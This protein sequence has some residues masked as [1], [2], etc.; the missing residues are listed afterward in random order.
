MNN[1]V[2]CRLVWI[3][4]HHFVCVSFWERTFHCYW[5]V[6]GII[7]WLDFLFWFFIRVWRLSTLLVFAIRHVLDELNFF[8]LEYVAEN[9]S[10][11]MGIISSFVVVWKKPRTFVICET[12]FDVKTSFDVLLKFTIVCDLFVTLSKTCFKE[13]FWIRGKHFR[14]EMNREIGMPGILELFIGIW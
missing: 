3:H 6:F 9:N 11:H 7:W 14:V 4:L 8:I 12:I 2:V 5:L 13:C 1:H 10:S